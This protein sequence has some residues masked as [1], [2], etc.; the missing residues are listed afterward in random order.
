MQGNPHPNNRGSEEKWTVIVK[1]GR[2]RNLILLLND[3]LYADGQTES[4][5]HLSPTSRIAPW[6]RAE[7]GPE[8]VEWAVS[9]HEQRTDWQCRSSQTVC[10]K[11]E[12]SL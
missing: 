9:G 7:T 10:A 6:A 1:N 4:G 3:F 12:A 8:G 5:R 2:K 11:Q